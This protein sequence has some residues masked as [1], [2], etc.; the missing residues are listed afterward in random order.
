MKKHAILGI[1]IFALL[2]AP[3]FAKSTPVSPAGLRCEYQT[4]PLGIDIVSPCFSWIL[5]SDMR[6]QSQSA[7]ELIVSNNA[8]AI[9]KLQ[10]NIWSTG[11]VNSSQSVQ[12]QYAGSPLQ[13]FTRY[14]WRVRVYD[15]NGV[16]SNWSE[17]AWFETAMLAPS[18][19]QASWIGDG[20]PQIMKTEEFYQ[21]NPSQM[22]RKIFKVNK[23]IKSSRLY[24]S[25]LGYY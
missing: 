7:Y 18:D 14:F 24:I 17:T 23:K 16:A 12:V 19:W 21:D 8:D 22:F 6:N 1:F 4:N 20:K 25:G 10:G 15:K 3:T 2:T 5:K 13:S 9:K 11:K